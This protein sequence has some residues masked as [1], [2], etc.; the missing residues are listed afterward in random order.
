[1][2]IRTVVLTFGAAA[3]LAP[4]AHADLKAMWVGV[5]GAT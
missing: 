2:K 5:N 4:A 1:M 3:M